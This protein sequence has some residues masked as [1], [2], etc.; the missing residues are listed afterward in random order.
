MPTPGR[1]A[2]RPFEP[3]GRPG[4]GGRPGSQATAPAKHRAVQP[5]RRAVTHLWGRGTRPLQGADEGRSTGGGRAPGRGGVAGCCDVW[6]REARTCRGLGTGPVRAAAVPSRRTGARGPHLAARPAHRGRRPVGPSPG[7]PGCTRRRHPPPE[8][9]VRVCDDPRYPAWG[10]TPARRQRGPTQPAP[11][12]T[13]REPPRGV[14][15]ERCWWVGPETARDTTAPKRPRSGQTA[16]WRAP[17][18]AGES[19]GNR[20]SSS[21]LSTHIETRPRIPRCQPAGR[22]GL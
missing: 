6:C 17:E 7:R 22:G 15:G 20:A 14:G 2:R 12:G 4:G 3:G 13:A 16:P 18:S 10:G 11:G 8:P 1:R 19:S 9:G 21:P 5:P